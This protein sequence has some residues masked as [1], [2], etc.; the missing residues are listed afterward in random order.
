MITYSIQ[1]APTVQ[2]TGLY[3][4][5]GT[6]VMRVSCVPVGVHMALS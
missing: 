6:G 1:G 2:D 4:T 5:Y 3:E